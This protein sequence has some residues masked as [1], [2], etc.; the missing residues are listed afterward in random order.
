MT[1]I[2][3][4]VLLVSRL[5]L[6]GRFAVPWHQ[7][8]YDWTETQVNELL[9]DIEE[10]L[11]EGRQSYFLGS[12]ML[13]R[14]GDIWEINDGQQRLITLTLMFAAL[15][16]CFSEYPSVDT[17]R[18]AV[19]DR[20]LFDVPDIAV[21]TPSDRSRFTPRVRPPRP[22]KSRFEQIIRGRDIGTNGRLTAAWN[23][24]RPFFGAMDLKK[25]PGVLQLSV[26]TRRTSS[27]RRSLYRRRELDIRGAKRTW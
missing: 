17:A 1:R 26:R 11:S 4:E 24:I 21:P 15:S 7:R 22:D 14:R 3:A 20:M 16:R 18:V 12:I 2:S 13:V 5:L 27:A 9:N 8:Y 25:S 6:K 10:A 19:C 23:T